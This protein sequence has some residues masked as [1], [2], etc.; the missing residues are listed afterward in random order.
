M[1]LKNSASHVNMFEW[2]N[3]HYTD[4][5]KRE[6]FL[7]M[8]IALKYIHSHGYCIE[9]FYPSKIEILNDQPDHIQFD[10]LMKL[11]SDVSERDR[12]IREDLFNSS[13]IQIGIYTNTLKYLTPEF[14]KSNFDELA[15]FIPE[16]DIP[17]YRGVVQRG[18]LVYFSEFAVEKMNRD[19]VQLQH[20]IDES[21]G[22]KSIDSSFSDE[23]VSENLS[24][25]KINDIIYK[26]LSNSMD[27]NV[28]AFVNGLF[29]PILIILSIL[30]L[31]VVG[32]LIFYF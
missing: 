24:N 5:E 7:N 15:K 29:V 13:L 30:L 31:F 3:E 18:A 21:E 2:F 6:I 22:K 11:S 19:L 25:D 16:G 32:F 14:L 10:C 4:E 20:Q 9:C 8:D 23:K 17:Y 12:L 27:M 28:S 26:Q 1:I